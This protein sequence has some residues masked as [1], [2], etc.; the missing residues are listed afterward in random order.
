[1][2]RF[3][4][5]RR[6]SG[7][8]LGPLSAGWLAERENTEQ[9]GGKACLARS[10]CLT[11]YYSTISDLSQLVLVH[12]SSCIITAQQEGK[13]CSENEGKFGAFCF[14]FFSPFLVTN[15]LLHSPFFFF[16]F[17]LFS[18]RATLRA[19]DLSGGK[20]AGG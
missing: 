5:A 4:G 11:Y 3:D 18:L 1:M 17:L 6:L 12:V 16:P 8:S 19:Q 10:P 7:M 2:G 15:S 20:L 9:G 14:C 13:G